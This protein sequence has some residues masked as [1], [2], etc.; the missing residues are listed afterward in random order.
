MRTPQGPPPGPEF[1]ATFPAMPVAAPV[2]L[3]CRPQ[4]MRIPI[5]QPANLC[6]EYP[7]VLKVPQLPQESPGS[8]QPLPALGCCRCAA[9][10]PCFS[11]CR[12]L[13]SYCRSGKLLLVS[14][15]RLRFLK[16]VGQQLRHHGHAEAVAQ[17]GVPLRM[18][19]SR[20]GGGGG[21][22]ATVFG[23]R[24]E[25]RVS[26][27]GRLGSARYLCRQSFVCCKQGARRHSAKPRLGRLRRA[28]RGRLRSKACEAAAMAKQGD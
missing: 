9:G 8:M 22:R 2:C 13:A 25:A 12:Y 18:Q 26:P 28:E 4:T 15:C 19:R 10:P 3:G 5:C 6:L 14:K 11:C 1:A 21:H 16:E 24:F 20:R 27:S 17:Q 23:I 7:T